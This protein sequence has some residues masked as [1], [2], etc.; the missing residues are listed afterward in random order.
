[1]WNTS[2][3]REDHREREGNPKGEISER[4]MNHERLWTTRNNLGVSEGRGI[5]GNRVMGIEE[6]MCY[7]E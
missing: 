3:S 6:G 4:K 2:N 7:D 5:R 1:M